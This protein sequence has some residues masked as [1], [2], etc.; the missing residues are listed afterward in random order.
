[1]IVHHQ[2][3]ILLQ[4]TIFDIKIFRLIAPRALRARQHPQRGAR[5]VIGKNCIR[6][7]TYHIRK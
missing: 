3:E 1:M 6:H 5:Q 2:V 4:P 7:V